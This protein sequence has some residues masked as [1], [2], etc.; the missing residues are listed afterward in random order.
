M[1]GTPDWN[2]LP[3]FISVVESGSM[4]AAARKLGAP[5]SSV[6]RGVAALEAALGVQLLHRTTREVQPTTAGQAFYE[7]ARPVVSAYREL[8]TSLPEQEAEP[9]GT[10]RLTTPVDMRLSFVGDVFANF[11]ARYPRVRL[12]VVPTNRVVDLVAEGFDA[13]LRVAGKLK[14]SSL[15]ARRLGSVELSIF[16][17]PRYLAQFG[18]P[19]SLDELEAHR[20]VLFTQLRGLPQQLRKLPAPRVST[21]D[22]LFALGMARAAVGLT[23]LPAHLVHDDVLAG[24]LVRVVPGWRLSYG[25]LFFLHPPAQHVPRK[26]TALRDYLLEVTAQRPLG[27]SEGAR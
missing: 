27:V 16:G 22:L 21:D 1:P 13:G 20:W 9:S 17:A 4:S 2:L 14:D 15:L 5:K 26:V 25:S 24:N 8:T 10:L 23:I 7:R 11:L 6:S 18:T 3:L 12:E 19:R